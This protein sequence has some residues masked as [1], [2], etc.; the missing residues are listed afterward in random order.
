MSATQD[1]RGR[2]GASQG[3]ARRRLRTP[4]FPQHEATECGAA[5][6]GAVLGH[7][8]RWAPIEELREAC[9]V[10]RD[11]S[12]AADLAAAANQYGLEVSAWSK[13]PEDLP[14]LGLPVILFWSST[15]SWCWKG[16]AAGCTT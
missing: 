15:T 7:F 9:A 16:L 10:S 8:G 11:G 3:R 1:T 6:L 5:C 4:I 2:R 12:T 14:E 13:E